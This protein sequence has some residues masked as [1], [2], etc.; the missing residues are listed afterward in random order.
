M[1]HLKLFALLT[2][3]TI[4]CN[5]EDIPGGNRPF[6]GP[7]CVD[8]CPEEDVN[9]LHFINN[10]DYIIYLKYGQSVDGSTFNHLSSTQI[11][12]HADLSMP[13][14]NE[15]YNHYLFYKDPQR[16]VEIGRLIIK[17][18][19]PF[20]VQFCTVRLLHSR[21]FSSNEKKTV[22]QNQRLGTYVE[23]YDMTY[24]LTNIYH[25]ADSRFPIER[26]G[27]ITMPSTPSDIY[28]HIDFFDYVNDTPGPI[29]SSVIYRNTNSSQIN[30]PYIMIR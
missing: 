6:P 23:M 10:D 8:H 26:C 12:N 5:N 28:R 1:K 4:S 14:N 22:F 13:F 16:S 21:T 20:L 7:T 25:L 18:T 24:P 30:L 17:N 27:S 2:L 11:N 19:Q 9:F 3:L 29:L 15:T